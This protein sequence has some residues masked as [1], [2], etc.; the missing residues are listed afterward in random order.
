MCET[1]K[2][3]CDEKKESDPVDAERFEEYY[4]NYV[5]PNLGNYEKGE[6]NSVVVMDNCSVH[7][8]EVERMTYEAG[9]ILLY[10]APYSPELNPIEYMFGEWKKFLARYHHEFTIDWRHIHDLGLASITPEM[11]LAF[12]RNTTLVDLVKDHPLLKN[13]DDDEEEMLMLCLVAAYACK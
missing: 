6:A 3:S 13:S 2:H 5:V 9:A 12:F 8:G 11:G 1:I 10:S 4:R 7:M